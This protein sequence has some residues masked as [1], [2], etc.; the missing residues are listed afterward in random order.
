MR[1]EVKKALEAL[2]QHHD[3]VLK[4][5]H[6]RELFAKDA[7]RFNKMNVQFADVDL[8]FDYSKNIVTEETLALLWQLCDQADLSGA[9]EKMFSGEHINST[10]DRAVLHVA[11]RD[12]TGWVS[13]PS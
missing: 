1:P 4:Q 13:S 12:P 6:M 11:L 9:I 5:A 7:A 2:R 3:S 10:E 8:L